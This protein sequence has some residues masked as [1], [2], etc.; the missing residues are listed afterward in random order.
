M[1]CFRTGWCDKRITDADWN[2]EGMHI[3]M[4]LDKR[5][6]GCPVKVMV[7]TMG[8]AQVPVVFKVFNKSLFT[9]FDE[10]RSLLREIDI[11]RSLD[12]PNI[13]AM[14]GV[15]E[16]KEHIY[17]VMERGQYDMFELV[18]K[19]GLM[20]ESMFI[21][22]VFIPIVDSLRYLH[23]Q[24]IAHLDIKPEN[25]IYG[26]DQ[27]WKLADFGL[28]LNYTTDK[29]HRRIGTLQYMSP[30]AVNDPTDISFKSDMWALGILYC[31]IVHG[32]HPFGISPREHFND[33]RRKL[34]RPPSFQKG[35]TYPYT[36]KVVK[37]CLELRPNNRP[38][39]EEII[40]NSAMLVRNS[41]G[42]F[43]ER[44]ERRTLQHVPTF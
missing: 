35:S 42:N 18:R 33:H 36:F 37:S 23:S 43:L 17:I 24:N 4:K 27:R 38:N 14:Y 22:D 20:N 25:I 28:S 2:I 3:D 11:H 1:F 5:P 10:I 32:Y 9:K 26:F 19:A 6:E 21:K 41:P 16:D 34:S 15:L 44:I 30:E 40:R 8:T 29:P 7:G 31:E 12:H 39:A 13:I